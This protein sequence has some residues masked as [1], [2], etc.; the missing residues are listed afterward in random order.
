MCDVCGKTATAQRV[1][2]PEGK[3]S[4]FVRPDEWGNLFV[5]V[6]VEDAKVSSKKDF[7]SLDCLQ[8]AMR[9]FEDE[10]Y[11]YEE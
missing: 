10:A 1:A 7:C 2:H 11:G 5:T 4:N 8:K 9:R 6:Q 3:G